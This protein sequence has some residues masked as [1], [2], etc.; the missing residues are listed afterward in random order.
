MMSYL[1]VGGV[2][3]ERHP[4]RRSERVAVVVVVRAESSGADGDCADHVE[5]LGKPHGVDV[6][7]VDVAN[8]ARVGRVLRPDEAEPWDFVEE[9]ARQFVQFEKMR[10]NVGGRYAL[11]EGVSVRH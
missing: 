10:T 8:V 7:Q 4:K 9:P 6:L 11:E 5:Q 2:I 3:A 1:R